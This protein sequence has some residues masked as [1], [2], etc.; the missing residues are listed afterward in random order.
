MGA[1]PT[2]VGRVRQWSASKTLNG[3][4]TH[5]TASEL[6][7]REPQTVDPLIWVVRHVTGVDHGVEQVIGARARQRQVAG[8]GR[9]H[10]RDLL[11]QLG[12]ELQRVS[13]RRNL[14]HASSYRA[15]QSAPSTAAP[16]HRRLPR[17]L[18]VP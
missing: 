6:V 11:R 5:V 1:V 4:L 14:R 13:S 9:R 12:Q 3:L 10:G 8:H 15:D 7:G 18:S 17:G 16:P 2:A